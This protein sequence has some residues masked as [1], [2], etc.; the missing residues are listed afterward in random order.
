MSGPN[1]PPDQQHESALDRARLKLMLE[2]M[3]KDLTAHIAKDEALTEAV[4][5]KMDGLVAMKVQIRVVIALLLALGGGA[6]AMA[7]W[8]IGHA[9]FDVLIEAKVL[10]YERA[11]P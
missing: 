9:V 1:T 4:S 5:T 2:Q 10:K 11:N 7:K 6:A 3:S 8:G